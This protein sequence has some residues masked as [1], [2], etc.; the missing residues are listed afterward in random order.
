VLHD[1]S[2]AYNVARVLLSLLVSLATDADSKKEN[3]PCNLGS[4]DESSLGGAGSV[5]VSEDIS[6]DKSG[7]SEPGTRTTLFACASAG[8][9][10]M[11]W[12][13]KRKPEDTFWDDRSLVQSSI[14]SSLDIKGFT[15]GK[16][17][18]AEHVAA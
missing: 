1:W 4:D 7:E 13:F 5:S 17:C 11:G 12:L 9:M 3:I 2:I 18:N 16:F 6:M 8:V 15:S 14:R 10:R